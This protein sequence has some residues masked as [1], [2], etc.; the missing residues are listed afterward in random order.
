MPDWSRRLRARWACTSSRRGIP[1]L[2]GSRRRLPASPGD[3][4][5]IFHWGR[6]L[7]KGSLSA[8]EAQGQRGQRGLGVGRPQLVTARA[9]PRISGPHV[10]PEAQREAGSPYSAQRRVLPAWGAGTSRPARH[11]ICAQNLCLIL[12]ASSGL[13]PPW[14]LFVFVAPPPWGLTPCLALYRAFSRQY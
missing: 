7:L 6:R 10:S 5:G 1:H 12:E 2:E 8:G 13:D 4:A 11:R 9:A 3:R 14:E